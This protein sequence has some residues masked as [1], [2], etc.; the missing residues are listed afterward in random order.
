MRRI[1]RAIRRA[2]AD[3]KEKN[4]VVRVHA[5]VALYLLEEEPGFIRGLE[6]SLAM[7]LALRDDP[8]LAQ[9]E[10][11][12]VSR[13]RPQRP[14]RTAS[15]WVEAPGAPGTTDLAPTEHTRSA[16]HGASD[17]SSCEPFSST[18]LLLRKRYG[19]SLHRTA[20][21]R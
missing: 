21:V 5:E 18:G 8:L 3:G 17:V 10:F 11:R 4:L 7:K 15:T 19:V 16:A 14:H 1:E 12:L 9:D 2:W 13:R 20:R 6:K